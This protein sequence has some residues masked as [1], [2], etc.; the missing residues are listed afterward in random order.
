M[1]R[2]EPHFPA[3]RPLEKHARFEADFFCTNCG[4][5][6]YTQP[7]TRDERLGILVVRCTECGRYQP[8]GVASNAARV[9]LARFAA[10]LLFFWI[11]CVL[12]F[13]FGSTFGLGALQ[14]GHVEALTTSGYFTP[15]GVRLYRGYDPTARKSIWVRMDNDEQVLIDNPVYR[16][17]FT[18]DRELRREP[19]FFAFICALVLLPPITFGVVMSVVMWHVR[20]RWYWLL[21]ALPPIAAVVVMAIYLVDIGDRQENKPLLFAIVGFAVAEQIVMI[22]LGTRIGRPIARWIVSLVVPPRPRQALSF[23]WAAD[24]KTLPSISREAA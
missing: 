7:V 20:R 10:I 14:S 21:A 24:G 6:L 2:E 8:A 12:G 1:D 17:T 5:N 19:I 22:M 3:Q 18:V 13:V 9:W 4:Y 15:D 16:R 11:V 23:L